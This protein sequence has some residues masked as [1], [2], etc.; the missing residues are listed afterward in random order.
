MQKRI[1]VLK[2]GAAKKDMVYGL[3]CAGALV[4]LTR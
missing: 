3:C 4:P 1:V 2:K